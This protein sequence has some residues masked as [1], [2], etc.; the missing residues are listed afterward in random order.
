M[1]TFDPHPKEV[2]LGTRIPRLTTTEE[3][4][5]FFSNQIIIKFTKAI[6]QMNAEDF[7][8]DII[9]KYLNPSCITIGYDFKFGVNGHGCVNFLNEWAKRKNCEI[10]AIEKQMKENTPY[11]SS[12]I[13]SK[14]KTNPNQAFEFLGHPYLIIGHVIHGEKRGRNLGFPTANIQVPKNKCIPK[15]GV[16]KSH[17]II[18]NITYPSITNIGFKPSFNSNQPS[19]ETHILNEF[20]QN[21]YDQKVELFLESFIRSEIKFTSSEA[22]IKQI[23]N[24]IQSCYS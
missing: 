16:Y 20:N 14:I 15:S 21:I 18:D 19:I 9:Q 12:F 8:N 7:L 2:L 1:V 23:K 22:L 6:A 13:R 3:Q 24:D 4:R 17:V 11:K 5:R 10:I